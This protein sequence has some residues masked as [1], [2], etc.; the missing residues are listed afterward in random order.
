MRIPAISAAATLLLAPAFASAQ[1]RYV[2]APNLASPPGYSHA[3]VVEHGKIIYLSGAVSADAHGEV[4]GHGDF[5]AQATQ[6]FE[7]LRAEL[8]AVGATTASLVKLNYYVVGL[9]HDKVLALREVR[10]KF[11]DRD[12]L[13]ASTLTGA[14]ALARDE[15]MIEIEGVAVVP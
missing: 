10:D 8:A 15:Y 5:R 9:D 1:A 12:H 13:P 7:N 2:N 6:A 14:V 3:V 4:V 11:L